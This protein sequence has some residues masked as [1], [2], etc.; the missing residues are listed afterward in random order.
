MTDTITIRL[1][2]EPAMTYSDPRT[3][4][5]SEYGLP[6]HAGDL[7]VTFRGEKMRLVGWDIPHKPDSTGR[8][9]IQHLE[10]DPSE[11]TTWLAYFPGVINAKFVVP[12]TSDQCEKHP[13]MGGIEVRLR[14]ADGKAM[15][16]FRIVACAECRARMTREG[17]TVIPVKSKKGVTQ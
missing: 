14:T 15:R 6:L 8:V 4:L 9:Y 3:L 1:N 17:Y 12:G 13:T 11:L 10:R 16:G 7:V 5:V 2:K